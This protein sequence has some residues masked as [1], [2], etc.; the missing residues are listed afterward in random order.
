[1]VIFNSKMLEAVYQRV[2]PM[3]TRVEDHLVALSTGRPG[4]RLL[5]LTGRD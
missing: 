3:V 1:M 5:P 4:R 2:N